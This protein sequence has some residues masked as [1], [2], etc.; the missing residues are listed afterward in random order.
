MAPERLRIWTIS[1][2]LAS[3]LFLVPHVV[4]DLSE[5]LARRLGLASDLLALLLGG[6]LALQSLGLVLVGQGRR[7]G[8]VITAVVGLIW[9][10]GAIVDH[11]PALLAGPFRSGAR[12]VLW[13]VGLIVGQAAST[14]LAGWGAGRA[15]AG[16]RA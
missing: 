7:T 6:F 3:L 12:S 10:A 11:G 2:S 14:A 16:R 8:F 13:V 5:G 9:V 15:G 1:V 4:E